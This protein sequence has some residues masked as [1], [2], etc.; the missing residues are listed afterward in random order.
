MVYSRDH[1][2]CSESIS[3]FLSHSRGTRLRGLPTVP[4]TFK[5]FS[6]HLTKLIDVIL[7]LGCLMCRIVLLTKT[8]MNSSYE[9]ID[10]MGMLYNHFL[11]FS[12]IAK[13]TKLS[14]SASSFKYCSLIIT[15][16]FWNALIKRY[17]LQG[18]SVNF[19][20]ML[21]YCS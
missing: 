14:L 10:S 5:R 1:C 13:G 17:H 3:I 20:S 6:C 4:I 2:I 11:M 12:L 8:V 15:Y 9:V 19:R 16:T 7:N 21:I 18:R